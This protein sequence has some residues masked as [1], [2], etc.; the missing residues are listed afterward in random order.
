M[1]QKSAKKCKRREG[2]W[3]FP[4]LGAGGVPLLGCPRIRI[5]VFWGLYW[6]FPI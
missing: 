1:S 6:G 2:V 3:E 4:K 5:I